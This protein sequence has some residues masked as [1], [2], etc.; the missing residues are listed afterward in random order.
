MDKQDVVYPLDEYYL[1]KKGMVYWHML[2]EVWT[3]QT[4]KQLEETN[5]KAHIL[6]NSICR[7]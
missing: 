5:H 2:Q 4:L 3:L 7:R 6:Y 1:T